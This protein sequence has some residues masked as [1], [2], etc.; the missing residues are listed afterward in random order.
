MSDAATHDQPDVVCRHPGGT[1]GARPATL[2]AYD[3]SFCDP[4]GIRR[5]GRPPWRRTTSDDPDPMSDAATHDQ[6]D[7][8]CRHPGGTT[9]TTSRRPDP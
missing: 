7:V 8:V 2:A 5:H 1:T 4:G 3:M 6:P 9:S